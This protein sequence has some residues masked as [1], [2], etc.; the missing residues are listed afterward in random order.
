M[1]KK[2]R[3]PEE[4]AERKERYQAKRKA[5]REALHAVLNYVR[6]RRNVP[7]EVSAAVKLITPGARVGSTGPK[8]L[9][10]YADLFTENQ[11]VT[12]MHVFEQFK[13]GRAEMRK[14]CVN[15]IKKRA[16]ADRIW[17]KLNPES[18]TYTVEGYGEN[19]PSNWTGYR[20]VEVENT[21][22]V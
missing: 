7:D 22:I 14:V 20:P 9:D 3:T 18:E 13:A 4:K 1:A 5:K 12:E 6:E 17:V 11:S 15:L 16:P 10:V 8:K 2:E 19:P 21:E